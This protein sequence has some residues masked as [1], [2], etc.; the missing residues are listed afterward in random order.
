MK[1]GSNQDEVS[2]FFWFTQFL[3]L[4]KVIQL[5]SDMGVLVDQV[6]NYLDFG[7]WC[8]ISASLSSRLD[9]WF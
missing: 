4:M 1:L 8:D 2:A 7:G 3:K 6:Q 5:Q 9:S